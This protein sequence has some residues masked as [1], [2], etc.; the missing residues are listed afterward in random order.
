MNR[1]RFFNLALPVLLVVEVPPIARP[2][3]QQVKVKVDIV[4]ARPE[5]MDAFTKAHPASA[6]ALPAEIPNLL[7]WL[8]V[9][10]ASTIRTITVTTNDDVPTRVSVTEPQ[11][12]QIPR[13]VHR[14]SFQHVSTSVSVTPRVNADGTITLQLSLEDSQYSLSSDPEAPRHILTQSA[15][16]THSADSGE[17]FALGPSPA[18][19]GRELLF[20]VTPTL[21]PTKPSTA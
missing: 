5:D 18:A 9:A 21:L 4:R 3:P 7:I 14:H 15:N 10:P 13:Q 19:D 8:S 20:F 12:A 11:S 16:T 6:S 17:T 1:R 2:G